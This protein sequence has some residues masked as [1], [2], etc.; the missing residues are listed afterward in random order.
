MKIPAASVP[1]NPGPP[2]GFAFLRRA[3]AALPAPIFDFLVGLGAAAAVFLMPEQRRHS[4]AY[5]RA[6]RGR[7][8][9]W[10]EPCRHF[11]EF[12]RTLVVSLRAARGAPYRC[13]GGPHDA[14][15]RAF[16]GTGGPALFGTFHLGQS[17][18]LGYIL[19]R[20]GRRIVM[21]RMKVGNSPDLALLSRQLGG[22]VDFLWV[23]GPED[24]A[25]AVKQ[26]VQS[27]ASLAMKCDRLGHSSKVEAFR[28]LGARRLFPF[29]IYHLA[30]IFRLPVVLSASIGQGP[31]EALVHSLPIFQ[32]DG[33]SKEAN[34]TRARA[35]F[36]EFIDLVENLLRQNPYLWFNFTPLNP[37]A[38]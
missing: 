3:E 22:G 34:L 37:E 14:P 36:Q 17:D 6:L 11:R 28:F 8:A 1:R 26:A 5:L 15:L 31:G 12:A 4:R 19:A 9:G 16:L 25:L 2:W 35:H 38:A 23:N 27:G 24:L 18:L 7:P 10:L 32:P 33:G 29:T 20:F 30:V 13:V 21:V